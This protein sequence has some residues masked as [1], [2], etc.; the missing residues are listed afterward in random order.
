M[1]KDEEGRQHDS[2]MAI[3]DKTETSQRPCQVST[4]RPQTAYIVYAC[5]YANA[6]PNA[7]CCCHEGMKSKVYN[8]VIN[9]ALHHCIL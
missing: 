1:K 4:G 9:V 5:Q 7:A 6:V 8:G 3:L 2:Q